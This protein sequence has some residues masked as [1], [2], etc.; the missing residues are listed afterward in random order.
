MPEMCR[1]QVEKQS[2]VCF[3]GVF[4]RC[5]RKKGIIN[6]IRSLEFEVGPQSQ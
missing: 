3:S 1:S 4:K 6:V 5:W 2:E